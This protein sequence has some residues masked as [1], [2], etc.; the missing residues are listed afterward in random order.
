MR[1]LKKLIIGGSND[2][3]KQLT[4]LLQPHA[5]GIGRSTGHDIRDPEIR[6]KIVRDSTNYDLVLLFTFVNTAQAEL[7]EKMALHWLEMKHDGHIIAFGTTAIYHENFKQ[8]ETHWN[9]LRHK[10]ALQALGKL[11]THE[12]A[13]ESNPMRYSTLHVGR[14][15]NEKAR[16]KSNFGKALRPEEVFSAIEFLAN[17]PKNINIHELY[18]DP[19]Y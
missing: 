18:L 19:K 17:Q 11:I 9:Y 13:M 10:S 4:E 7:A 14:L 6:S 12:V 8:D 5:V 1:N 2:F 16:A 3:G 15:D